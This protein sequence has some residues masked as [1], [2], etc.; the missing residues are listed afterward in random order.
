[1]KTEGFR[2]TMRDTMGG[3]TYVV[4]ITS[5]TDDVFHYLATV[6]GV[7][8]KVRERGVIR[9]KGDAMQLA[10]AAVERHIADLS[11]KIA[12]DSTTAS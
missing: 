2:H 7:D 3:H 8:V 12:H 6:D 9:N 4:T 5:P 1:M 10:L 11:H